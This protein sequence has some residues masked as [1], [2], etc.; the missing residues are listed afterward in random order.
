LVGSTRYDPS[1]RAKVKGVKGSEIE[2]F[3]TVK[4]KVQL[5]NI[6]VSY[7]FQLVQKQI[8]IPCDGII[9]RDF[10][11]CTKTRIYYG[12]QSVTIGK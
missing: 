4:A 8:D 7:E 1:K 11:L 10:L 2:I 3:G 12:M 5:G 9:G 6:S